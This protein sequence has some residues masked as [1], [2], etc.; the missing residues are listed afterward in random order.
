MT[1]T[2]VPC[3]TWVLCW[4]VVLQGIS[5]FFLTQEL[6]SFLAA[7]GFPAPIPQQQCRDSTPTLRLC[8]FS[9]LENEFVSTPLLCAD[10]I[11]ACQG[12]QCVSD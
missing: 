5:S 8:S 12:S 7:Y 2:S 4:P 10:L 9:K 3:R 11:V 1:V 6:G